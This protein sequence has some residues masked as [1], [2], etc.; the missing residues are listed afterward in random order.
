MPGRHRW[1]EV[2]LQSQ[3][4]FPSPASWQRDDDPVGKCEMF[5]IHLFVC[6]SVCLCIRGGAARS[7]ES[8]CVARGM[9]CGFI[10][11]Q[12]LKLCLLSAARRT[13]TA[14]WLSGIA[15]AATKPALEAAT[16]AAA[17]RWEAEAEAQVA[18]T[19]TRHQGMG[20]LAG[21]LAQNECSNGFILYQQGVAN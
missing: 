17:S 9:S 4:Q 5:Y 2:H 1:Q 16:K 14:F 18:P 13:P 19:T 20:F 8:C 7:W 15:K 10:A 6:L 21:I 12:K 11:F 3:P